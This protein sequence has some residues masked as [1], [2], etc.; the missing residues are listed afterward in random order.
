MS[1][2]AVPLSAFHPE[3]EWTKCVYLGFVATA[4]VAAGFVFLPRRRAA[5]LA[6]LLLCVV[7]II[8]GDSNVFSRVLWDVLPPLH[9]VRYPGNLSYL[10]L[11]P[12]AALVGA[13]L[14]RLRAAPVLTALLAVEL[15]ACGWLATPVTPRGVFTEAGPLVRGL[16]E[17]LAGTRYLLSP[18]ALES[19]S[20]TSVIDWKT[21]LYG[22]TNAP[23]RLRA[24]GN[25]GE[26]LVPAPGY[27]FMD[28]IFSAG[29]VTE[30]VSWMPWA[31]ASR[32][33]TPERPPPGARLVFEGYA[34]WAVSRLVEPP[35]LAYLF[36]TEAGAALPAGL[37]DSPPAVGRA[38][39]VERPR[40]DRFTITGEGEGFVF[41]SEPRYPG[42]R[43]TLE[44]PRGT[45]PAA[46]EPA[47]GAFQK[48][49]VPSG[50]WTL[51]F[52]YDP[53]SWRLGVL[54]STAAL[55]GLGAYWYHRAARH[56]A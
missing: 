33:L 47:L 19:S 11:L 54:L 31:G 35:A 44:T 46:A 18:R 51:L 37:P 56:V 9:F 26:P 14:S 5:G 48:A 49:P 6:G 32:L 2:L 24:V 15:L 12:L 43:S 29:S 39:A 42:W 55:L 28:R 20:G 30:A 41:V 22:L 25:F 52:R 45:L 7:V 17:R 16:Q 3:V 21:R 4:A 10:A 13:G 23:Y 53:A 36:S 40:E 8:L 1:P 34:P 50:P 27:A 38:L